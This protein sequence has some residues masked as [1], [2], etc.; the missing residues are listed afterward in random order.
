M[1][2]LFIDINHE[3]PELFVFPLENI[4]NF[5]TSLLTDDFLESVLEREMKKKQRGG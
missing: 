3:S 1:R 4:E 2:A 5:Q